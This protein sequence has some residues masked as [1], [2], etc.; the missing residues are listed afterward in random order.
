MNRAPQEAAGSRGKRPNPEDASDEAE[1]GQI[2]RRLYESGNFPRNM[3][4]S[5][6]MLRCSEEICDLG[7]SMTSLAS[8][9]RRE[10]A[11][12]LG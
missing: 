7:L 2:H 1:G 4:F 10:L 8:G 12:G 6:E 3:R 9:G 5:L 11:G